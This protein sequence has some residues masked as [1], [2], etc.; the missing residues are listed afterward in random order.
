M[1]LILIS[2]LAH[3]NHFTSSTL[4]NKKNGCFGYLDCYGV[5]LIIPYSNV[6][7]CLELVSLS[8]RYDTSPTHPKWGA[9]IPKSHGT[10]SLNQ[11]PR[12]DFY[13]NLVVNFPTMKMMRM[14]KKV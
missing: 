2:T 12:I 4:L 1:G 8:D 3:I 9:E 5:S 10:Q 14:M 7:Q 13:F 11:G 6:V